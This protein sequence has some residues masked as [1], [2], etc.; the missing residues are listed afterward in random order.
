MLPYILAAV[1]GY[2]IG[3]SMKGKQFADGGMM[4][5]GE[6]MP[7]SEI[8]IYY[9]FRCDDNNRPSMMDTDESYDLSEHHKVYEL[10][11]ELDVKGI[12]Y[13]LLI[14]RFDSKSGSVLS[15]DYIVQKNYKNEN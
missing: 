14:E 12:N 9:L 7:K 3:D 8:R 11:H 1:G 13:D 6:G 2:L 15:N 5:D 4:A 10:K